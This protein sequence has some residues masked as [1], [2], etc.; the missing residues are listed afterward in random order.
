VSKPREGG[1]I[2][3]EQA[4]NRS[5]PFL[6]L[7]A[8]FSQI[9]EEITEAIDR[10]LRSQQFILGPEV[11]AFEANMA[12][13][14][15]MKTAMGCASGSDALLL[16]LLALDVG[17][18]DEVIT[19]PFTFVATAGAIA[20][21]GAKPVFVDI[22]DDTYN[23]DVTRIEDVITARTRAIMPVHLFGLASD[24]DLMLK[25]ADRHG[26]KVVEDA[27]Q[28]IG[29][30]YKG[31]S[32][33]SIGAVGCFSFFPSKNLGAAG[34]GG[35][36]TTADPI[37]ED[38]LRLLRAHGSRE[39][40]RYEI[41]GV[42]SRLDAIQAAILGVKLKYLPQ[43][44]EARRAHAR[45]YHDL[46]AHYGLKP[47]VALPVEPSGYYHVYNQF[48]IRVQERDRLRRYLQ[49]HGIPT[50]IYYSVPLHLQPAFRYLGLA[51][52]SFPRSESA[53]QKVLALPIYPEM[54]PEQQESVVSTIAE[55]YDNM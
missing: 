43:W 27:A 3:A 4:E 47:M 20:R 14:L 50:E 46:F 16:A 52:G 13:A 32:V 39:R 36:L 2:A 21:I 48:T 10:V 29:S 23:I 26:L 40:Y 30:R 35:L 44:T 18:G 15:A 11:E 6:D 17:V 42:N 55:F 45:A 34:D 8:Q 25:V 7:R 28:A 9:K 12:E 31:R 33:G 41:L 19:T 54:S 37:I 49:D 53:S 1:N 22:D 5:F 38:R 51:Q 24:M